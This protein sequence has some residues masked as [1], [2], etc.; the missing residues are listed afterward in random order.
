MQYVT[1]S[2]A[3]LPA[4]VSETKPHHTLQN[5]QDISEHEVKDEIT[6]SVTLIPTSGSLEF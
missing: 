6:D 4:A 1:K 5:T 2:I 3:D